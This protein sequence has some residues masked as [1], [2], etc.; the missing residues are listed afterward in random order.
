MRNCFWKTWRSVSNCSLCTPDDRAHRQQ[1]AI[2]LVRAGLDSD[3]V[4]SRFRNERQTLAGLDHPNIVKLLDG[5][6]SPEGT[7]YLVMDY[8]EGSPI[9]EYCDRQRLSVEE[10]LHLFGKVCEAVEHAH[11]KQ[12]IHRDLKPSNILVTAD[13]V[14][15]LLDLGI[16]KVLSAQVSD[17]ALRLTH[18]GARCMT[19]AYASPEQVRSNRQPLPLTSTRWA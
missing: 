8:V 1:V 12:V 16:A 15:K 9:D 6:S 18:T 19:P 14:P 11:Q 5:G 7:P 2:K 4:L 3:E 13:G 17:E 10:R